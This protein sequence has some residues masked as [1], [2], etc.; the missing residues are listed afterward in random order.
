MSSTENKSKEG[1]ALV[2]L[3]R[4]R[5]APVK[6]WAG[7][8]TDPIPAAVVHD[9]VNNRGIPRA[10]DVLSKKHGISVGRVESLWRHYYGGVNQL[11][12]ESGLKRPL[13]PLE[14]TVTAESPVPRKYKVSVAPVKSVPVS[15]VEKKEQK[16]A[17]KAVREEITTDNIAEND[18]NEFAELV[19]GQVAAGNDNPL[20]LEA[21]TT[22]IESNRDL[23]AASVK[24]LKAAKR[25]LEKAAKISTRKVYSTDYSGEESDVDHVPQYDSSGIINTAAAAPT[26]HDRQPAEVIAEDSAEY[27]EES[28]EE[29]IY[30]GGAN[31]PP[32]TNIR[33]HSIR[34]SRCAME[35]DKNGSGTSGGRPKQRASPVYRVSAEPT[36]SEGEDVSGGSKCDSEVGP[37]VDLAKHEISPNLQPHSLL[38]RPEFNQQTRKPQGI[39]QPGTSGIQNNARG[40]RFVRPN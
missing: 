29:D 18:P 22:M 30:T 26:G 38:H 11:C 9:V 10:R 33:P 6:P 27:S 28:S 12:F 14:N 16:M 19:S 25:A 21:I 20:L 3:G 1:A 8:N 15:A 5:K 17:A 36:V 32:S 40:S 23:T 35:P 37:I 31:C 2:R 7:R 34:R 24:T 4:K 13:P 39:H